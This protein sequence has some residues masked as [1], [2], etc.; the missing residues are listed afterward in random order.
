MKIGILTFQNTT[1]YGA[2]FQAYALQTFINKYCACEILNYTNSTLKNRYEI[3]PF[4]AKS[5]KEFIKKILHYKENKK[6]MLIFNEFKRTNLK[7][8]DEEYNED[9]IATADSKYDLFISG[10]DQVW[11]FKL[12]NYDKN[13]FLVFTNNKTKRN[14]YA[15]SLGVSNLSSSDEQLLRGLIVQQ[16]NISVRENEGKSLINNI[17][18]GKEKIITN[19]NID[20]VFLLSLKEWNKLIENINIPYDN[21]LLIYEVAYIPEIIEFAKKI[22]KEKKLK[23]LYVSASNKKLSEAITIKN[24]TPLQFLTYIKNAEII[25]TSSFHGMAFSTIFN[26]NFYYGIP[27]SKSN[28][29]SRLNSLAKILGLEDRNYVNYK[30]DIETIDYNKVN[31]KI[32]AERKRSKNY[33]EGVIYDEKV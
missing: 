11:N 2:M 9:N 7:I 5:I 1:N 12:T 32:L 23:I 15:A 18:S 28:F 10:S 8:S 19:V 26:K 6:N 16:N 24:I 33:I 4:K 31:K 27:K 13:Y 22:A 3:S 30:Q 14:S 25:I 20:P 17:T 29:G 21:Y